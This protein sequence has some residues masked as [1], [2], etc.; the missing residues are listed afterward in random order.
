MSKGKAADFRPFS[1]K[2]LAALTWWC[3]DSPFHDRDAIICDGAVRSGKTVCMSISFVAWALA[4][5]DGASFAL[6]G[7]T[8]ASLRRNV[9]TPVVPMLR[10]L[11][12][13]C[14]EK[15]SSNKLEIAFEKVGTKKIFA[16]FAKPKKI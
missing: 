4:S 13:D 7:K 8:I 6:C 9:I 11:G 14:R 10:E 1:E 3:P 16:N 5:F 2:Q 12:F 15:L